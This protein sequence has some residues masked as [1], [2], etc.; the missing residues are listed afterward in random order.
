MKNK[1][2]IFKNN[3]VFRVLRTNPL[4]TIGVVICVFW[5]FVI[6]FADYLAPYDPLLQDLSSRLQPPGREH[7]FGTDSLGRDILSRV[8]AGSRISIGAGLQCVIISAVAG[9]LIGGISGYIGGVFDDV[10]MRIGELFSSFPTIILAMVIAS[11]MGPSL[12]NTLLTMC[13]VWWPN[14]A[15]VMRAMVIQVKSNEYVEASRCLGASRMRI[16]IREILP[17]SISSVIVLTT[18]DFGNA[19][20]LFASLSYLG[21]GSPPPAPEWG[22][23]VS[24]GAEQFYYWWVATF[25]GLAILSVSL[26]ANFIGDGIRD[27]LD[28]KL[29]KTI[30]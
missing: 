22:A 26:G 18:V 8:L 4:L 13:I 11:A 27:Y 12:F 30:S 28:P 23:M 24:N 7:L 15:R 1:K 25:P 6:I 5:L 2:A 16:F 29:R 9:M 3:T 17:N 10:V 21:L 19:I 20:L 14:Y